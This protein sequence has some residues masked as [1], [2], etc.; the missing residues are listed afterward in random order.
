MARRLTWVLL[1][2][3][4]ATSQ[5]GCMRIILPPPMIDMGM[6][7]TIDAIKVDSWGEYPDIYLL[8]SLGGSVPVRLPVEAGTSWA[9]WPVNGTWYKP[10]G[11]NVALWDVADSPVDYKLVLYMYDYDPNDPPDDLMMHTQITANY[12]YGKKTYEVS[13][14][15][16][17]LRFTVE[18]VKLGIKNE[19]IIYSSVPNLLE[20]TSDSANDP[21]NEISISSED[22]R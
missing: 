5:F 17:A 11:Q 20:V 14:D 13:T 10:P 9:D 16:V 8:L 1:L 18:P 7:V 4:I 2:I 21:T 12:G 3:L 19:I 15:K 22:N 6:R